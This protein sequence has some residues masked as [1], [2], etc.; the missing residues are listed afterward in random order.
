LLLTRRV[1]HQIALAR[2]NLSITIVDGIQGL[3]DL[4]ASDNAR[5]QLRKVEGASETL[6]R[7]QAGV[8]RLTALQNSL[9]GLLANLAMLSVLV[10][11][12]QSVSVGMLDGV[13]LGVV[14]L[15]ALTSFEAIFPLPLAAQN[16]TSNHEAASRLYELVDASP[17]VTDPT[18]PQTLP[19][20]THIEADQLAFNYSTQPAKEDLADSKHFSLEDISFSLPQGKHIAII[21]PSGA[22]KTTLI[23]LL[24]RFWDYQHGS[25]R[26]GEYEMRVYDQ[27][28]IRGR[29]AA[30]TQGTYLFSA[31]LR[32]NLLIARPGATEEDIT[33]AI[34][35][36]HLKELVQSLPE[37][38]NTWIGEHGQQLSA[39]E[40]QRLAIA[41]S[42]LREAPLLLLDEP[43]A[44]LD[45]ATEAAVLNSIGELSYQRS[46][47]NITQR[48]VGLE[49]MDEILVLQ[50]GRIVERGTHNECRRLKD[51][52][53]QPDHLGKCAVAF[54]R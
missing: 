19:A 48:M 22:G 45:A 53:L 17:A 39:G 43:T 3:Q 2:A 5:A 30:I 12:I 15:A 1:G 10:L 29:I 13:L 26:M 41:R 35:A 20:D 37:G 51:V 47:I 33:Q 18:K 23:N 9:G 32:E 44:N 52:E 6:N 8:A 34:Q 49:T 28:D 21:G 50:E 54:E 4:L 7:Q 46:L 14:G 42:I 11:A 40:R 24:Q 25:L 38:T 27:E 36:A 31:T 16:Y